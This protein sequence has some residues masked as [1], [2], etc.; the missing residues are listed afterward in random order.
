MNTKILHGTAPAQ[1]LFLIDDPETGWRRYSLNNAWLAYQ[2]EIRMAK[3]TNIAI[4]V[5]LAYVEVTEGIPERLIRLQCSK[6]LINSDGLVDQDEVMRGIL[7]RLNPDES[8]KIDHSFISTVAI[9]D[10]D[11]AAIKRCLG[12]ESVS[13]A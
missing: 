5:V 8:L 10:E 12:I 4:R 3:L 2:G 6:W 13:S 11:I 1:P 9:S 7:E